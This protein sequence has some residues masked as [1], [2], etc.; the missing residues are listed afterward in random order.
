RGIAS[1]EFGLAIEFYLL[2]IFLYSKCQQTLIIYK[3]LL[4]KIYT[5]IKPS[6]QSM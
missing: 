4:F 1:S 3:K 2:A 5:Q 6:A